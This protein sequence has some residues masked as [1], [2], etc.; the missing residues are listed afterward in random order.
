MLHKYTHTHIYIY[1][2]YNKFHFISVDRKHS[3]K[4]GNIFLTLTAFLSTVGGS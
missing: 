1:I 3:M 2:Y 4:Q